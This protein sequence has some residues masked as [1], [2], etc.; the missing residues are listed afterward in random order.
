MAQ[1][2]GS[3]PNRRPTRPP[4]CG[5]LPTGR[6]AAVGHLPIDGTSRVTTRCDQRSCH[7]RWVFLQTCPGRRLPAPGPG[8]EPG[9]G[10]LEGDMGR[11]GDHEACWGQAPEQCRSARPR[12]KAR[13]RGVCSQNQARFWTAPA[14]VARVAV[15]AVAA[16][17]TAPRPCWWRRA[18]RGRTPLRASDAADT[19]LATRVGHQPSG[20]RSFRKQRTVNPP[21]GA[22]RCKFPCSPAGRRLRAAA[23]GEATLAGSSYAD[24]SA[25][26][27]R[28][29]RPDVTR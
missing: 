14:R 17:S 21:T 25:Y 4:S 28:I 1:I 10:P 13:G 5:G 11:A 24:G 27:R 20:R 7:Q 3:T 8:H 12:V 2:L 18:V 19:G 29:N 22:T 26:G 16:A 23:C 15:S 9:T 6:S